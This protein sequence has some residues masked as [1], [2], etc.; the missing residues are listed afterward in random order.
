M[1]DCE[2]VEGECL[3]LLV[4]AEC[5][6]PHPRL[7]VEAVCAQRIADAEVYLRVVE[8]EVCLVLG[9]ELREVV[10]FD[11]GHIEPFALK[12]VFDGAGDCRGV[13]RAEFVA[14]IDRHAPWH[15]RRRGSGRRGEDERRPVDGEVRVEQ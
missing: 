4:V 9:E 8:Y 2:P 7:A 15:V 14:D 1:S 3:G 11:R 5:G 10:Q 6:E 13:E 12:V